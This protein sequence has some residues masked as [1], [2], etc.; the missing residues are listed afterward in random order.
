MSQIKQEEIKGVVRN[1][2]TTYTAVMADGSRREL[3]AGEYSSLERRLD[4][5]RS[6]MEREG[7]REPQRDP[8]RRM[9]AQEV[10]QRQQARARE[11]ADRMRRR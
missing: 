10:Q 11:L 5:D 1:S 8:E 4:K 9:S 2:D 6:R 3:D 7:T